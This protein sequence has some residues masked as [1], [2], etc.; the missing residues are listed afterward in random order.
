VP[1]PDVIGKVSPGSPL[2]GFVTTEGPERVVVRRV[3]L[4]P[5]PLL[6]F[7]PV[8]EVVGPIYVVVSAASSHRV[9]PG[10]VG[11]PSPELKVETI[12]A[13]AGKKIEGWLVRV[14]EMMG[15]GKDVVAFSVFPIPDRSAHDV[16][17]AAVDKMVV[18]A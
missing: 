8:S 5:R 17:P 10:T 9:H 4:F 15:A 18:V 14:F 2:L 3:G 6:S 12:C 7:H 13:P 16:T 11:A 1:A